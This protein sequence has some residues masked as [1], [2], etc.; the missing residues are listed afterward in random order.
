[1]V[2]VTY[3]SKVLP[4]ANRSG[5]T[6]LRAMVSSSLA[7]VVLVGSLH[8]EDVVDVRVLVA[9]EA[10]HR[11]QAADVDAARLDVIHV[12]AHVEVHD[13]AEHHAVGTVAGRH[14]L[15]DL[16]F[17]ADGRAEESRRAHHDPRAHLEPGE[18]ELVDLRRVLA[19]GG[20]AG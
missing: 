18:G 17:H 16:A 6:T 20:V 13:L 1:P 11:L 19:G 7:F 9:G 15:D 8:F 10:A 3:S 4:L 12:V 14:D 2:Y 5:V